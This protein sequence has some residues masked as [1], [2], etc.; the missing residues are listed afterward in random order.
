M[1]GTPLDRPENTPDAA[2]PAR[3]VVRWIPSVLL[4]LPPG[5][6]ARGLV[7]PHRVSLQALPQT[8]PELLALLTRPAF[9]LAL[10]IE[11]ESVPLAGAP[12]HEVHEARLAPDLPL[13]WSEYYWLSDGLLEDI[14]E[15]AAAP[16]TAFL[17]GRLR[18]A[19]VED[20]VR[21]AGDEACDLDRMDAVWRLP[22]PIPAPD[23]ES[24]GEP[25]QALHQY[26]RGFAG[27]LAEHAGLQT[28]AEQ[29]RT[30]LA[31][32]EKRRET[33]FPSLGAADQRLLAMYAQHRLFG[34][35]C[36]I[37]PAGM[38]AGWHLLFS[39]Q[40]VALWWTGLLLRSKRETRTRD[41]LLHSLWLLDQGLW[42]DDALVHDVLRH[43]NAS[44]YTS[45]GL[46]VTL[47]HAFQGSGARA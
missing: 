38:I 29:V 35:P 8:R 30:L 34:N 14:A 44:E 9:E 12:L 22:H 33:A 5:D 31:V 41:A 4:D 3:T 28:F 21:T 10:E 26:V 7:T 18:L 47:A 36:L 25:T 19:L 39:A 20:M 40:L 32:A 2:G 1:D 37:A 23:I 46:A 27:H 24:Y 45:V 17:R 15:N 43:L 6:S 13:R 42:R 16:A 11:D